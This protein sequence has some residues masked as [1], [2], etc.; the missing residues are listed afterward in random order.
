MVVVGGQFPA[1]GYFLP[2]FVS[3]IGLTFSLIKYSGARPASCVSYSRLCI[4]PILLFCENGCR[5]FFCFELPS[6]DGCA[7]EVHSS[8]RFS[9]SANVQYPDYFSLGD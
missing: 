2:I 3:G 6:L 1:R 7:R 8:F 4:A 5:F 9:G